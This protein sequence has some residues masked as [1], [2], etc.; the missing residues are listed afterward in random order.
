MSLS[1]SLKNKQ[2]SNSGNVFDDTHNEHKQKQKL[3]NFCEERGAIRV[4]H[5]TSNENN[6]E[7]ERYE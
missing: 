1:L 2:R 3:G 7:N 5:Q 4:K 6:V